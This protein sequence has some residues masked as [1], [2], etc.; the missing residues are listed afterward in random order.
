M[1]ARLSRRETLN[2]TAANRRKQAQ[3]QIEEDISLY[4]FLID[5]SA[6]SSAGNRFPVNDRLDWDIY[7]QLTLGRKPSGFVRS[8]PNTVSSPDF[9]ST[10]LG[11]LAASD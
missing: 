5:C 10:R 7:Q 8:L 1:N 9:R 6:V 2:L 3:A 11:S 4:A